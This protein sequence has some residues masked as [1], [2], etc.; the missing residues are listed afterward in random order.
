MMHKVALRFAVLCLLTGS[1]LT[2]FLAERVHAQDSDD[3][4]NSRL[5]RLEHDLNELQRQVYRSSISGA[6]G[7]SDSGD[8]SD[9][10]DNSQPAPNGNQALSAQLRMDQLE[11]EIRD[12]TGQVEEVQY[13]ISQLKTRLDKMQSDDELR[14]EALEHPGSQPSIAPQASSSSGSLAPTQGADAG[15]GGSDNQNGDNANQDGGNLTPSPSGV[16]IP[17]DGSQAGGTSGQPTEIAPNQ[18]PPPDDQTAAAPA[19]APPPPSAPV[20][21]P[22]GSA[23]QQYAYAFDLLRKAQYPDAQQAFI[24]F[25]K[26]HPKD[27]L[28]GNAQYWLGETYFVQNQYQQAAAIFAQGFARYPDSPK[29][30]DNLLKLGISLGDTGKKREACAVFAK[31]DSTYS[32]MLPAVKDRESQEKR[33]FGC[34]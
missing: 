13:G 32:K 20:A 4:V 25:L 24:Q 6:A 33:Q 15:N 31:L 12:L 29:A 5:D 3:T 22:G 2:P 26:K 19:A 18:G 21:L 34:S 27:S 30:S 8:E 9:N 23:Q 16:L 28:A 1:A 10:G 14:F 17:P 11:S 7:T